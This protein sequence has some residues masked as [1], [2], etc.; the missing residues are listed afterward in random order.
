MKGLHK[1]GLV[2]LAVILVS[3]CDANQSSYG[4]A[5]DQIDTE[6][7]MTSEER[8]AWERRGFDP[9]LFETLEAW[10]QADV[11]AF[12]TASQEMV[13]EFFES[14]GPREWTLW[15]TYETE[16]GATVRE[17]RSGPFTLVNEMRTLGFV[18]EDPDESG[19]LVD[20]E[21]FRDLD[22][23]VPESLRDHVKSE[24]TDE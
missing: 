13:I 1:I 20:S 4:D 21:E 2:A 9:R 19:M 5:R 11:A 23:E 16:D 15:D 7:P 14:D 6:T 17:Y 10:T 8:A 18:D 22:V 3:A 24:E 12:E